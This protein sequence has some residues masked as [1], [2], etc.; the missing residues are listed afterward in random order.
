MVSALFLCATLL[1]PTDATSASPRNDRAAYEVLKAKVG[2]NSDEHVDLALWCEQ[3]GLT[4]ERMKHLAMAVLIDGGNVKARGL[5]D[6]ISLQGRWE[7]LEKLGERVRAEVRVAEAL[8]TYN[9]RRG[10][11]P[12]TANA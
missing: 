8:A 7:R 10:R 11:M 9:K 3:H 5:L 4:A 2:R 6:M 1:G 12:Q